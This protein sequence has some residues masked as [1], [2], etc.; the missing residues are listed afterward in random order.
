MR[1]FNE[2][3]LIR[4]VPWKSIEMLIILCVLFIV[5]IGQSNQVTI[6]SKFDFNETIGT[7]PIE[8]LS[9]FPKIEPNIIEDVT[10]TT[11]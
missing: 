10:L 5:N 9:I 6:I 11:V 4:L 3:V 1:T 2:R 8:I 7:K